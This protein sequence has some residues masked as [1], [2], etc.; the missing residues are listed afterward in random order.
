MGT[1]VHT[2]FTNDQVKELL[3]KYADGGVG[4][5]YLQEILG[6]KNAMFFRMLQAYRKDPQGFSVDYKR[7]KAS[8]RLILPSKT[9]LSKSWLSTKKLF[10]TR[11]F[12]F[13]DT[14]TAMFRSD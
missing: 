6:I 5:K 9:T 4:R 14:T 3:Q 11:T 1:H 2:K 13:T 10:K 12:L 7:S 8:L